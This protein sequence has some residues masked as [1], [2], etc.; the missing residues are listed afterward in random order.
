M[1]CYTVPATKSS[2]AINFDPETGTLEIHGESYP[3][4]CSRFYQPM[5]KWLE[6]YLPS[7]QDSGVTLTMEIIYFNSSSSKTF[8]DL[9]DLL[10]AEAKS[11]TSI[12]VNWRYHPDN[13]TALECGEDFR[14]EVSRLSFN[15]VESR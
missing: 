13:E 14:E 11:G 7:V 3:E 6:N 10:E 8:M 4:N 9:F 2:P 15:L 1:K 12:T 5:F